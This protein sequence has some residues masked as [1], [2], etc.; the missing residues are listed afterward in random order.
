MNV[1]TVMRYYTAMPAYGYRMSNLNFKTKQL[2]ELKDPFSEECI[3]SVNFYCRRKKFLGEG[4]DFRAT[5]EFKNGG[6][7]GK[8]SFEAENFEALVKKVDT[9]IKSL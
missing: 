5:V 3:E 1:A 8:Q 7:Q 4:P 6:T 9:F 2:S